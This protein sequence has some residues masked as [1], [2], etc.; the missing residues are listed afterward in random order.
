M[1]R[2]DTLLL[3]TS[4]LQRSEKL[5][6]SMR[7]SPGFSVSLLSSATVDVDR[8]AV[9]GAMLHPFTEH[10]GA[11]SMILEEEDVVIGAEPL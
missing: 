4:T 3:C 7:E 8:P 5:R 9:H 11:E 6:S 1:I 10:V 2:T